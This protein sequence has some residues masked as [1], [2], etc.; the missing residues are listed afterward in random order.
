VAGKFRIT[1]NAPVVLTFA[2]LACLV[3]LLPDDVKLWFV[4]WPEFHDTRSYVGLVTHVLGH[5][6]WDH[7]LANFT[8]ILLLGPILE[9]RHGSRQLLVMILIT[10]LVTGLINVAFSSTF[11]LGASGI[12]FMLIV[13][14]S[15]A[16]I[17]EREIPL[18]FIAI[19]VIFMGREII[20]AFQDDNVSQLAHLIGGVI[21]G[22]F[23]FAFAR[24]A[25]ARAAVRMDKIGGVSA[26]VRSPTLP[27]TPP[28]KAAAKKP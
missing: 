18:T 13:L 28:A 9:E 27:A 14:A 3:Q 8:F 10:A 16:N 11:L 21:G 7:L 6:N 4:S 2:V 24:P 17:R 12:V 22:A 15:T 26:A 5:G 1:Y 25:G 19:A 20:N 23:G